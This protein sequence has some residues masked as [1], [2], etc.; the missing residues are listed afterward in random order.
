MEHQAAAVAGL[1]GDVGLLPQH[2][3]GAH[4]A[5][6]RIGAHQLAPVGLG[7]VGGKLDPG[8]LAVF[9]EEQQLPLVIQ[10]VEH[11][12][13]ALPLVHLQL[14]GQVH[15]QRRGLAVL[16]VRDPALVHLLPVRQDQQL[17]PVGAF[18]ALAQRVPFLVLLIR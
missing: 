10:R 18:K 17:P 11:G 9:K 8:G 12:Q 2:Q 4:R 5:L 16:K 6:V 3:H 1:H 13:H 15:A 14:G 7:L